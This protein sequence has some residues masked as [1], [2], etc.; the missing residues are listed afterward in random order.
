VLH[1]PRGLNEDRVDQEKRKTART[2]KPSRPRFGVRSAERLLVA[3]LAD[4]PTGSVLCTSLGRG[5]FALAAAQS[6]P[7]EVFCSFPDLYARNAAEKFLPQPCPNL[8]LECRADFP[9]QE[10]DVFALP[11]S[12]RGDAEFVR[13]LLQSGHERLRIGGMMFVA[14]DN[15]SD[16]WLHDELRKLFAKVTRRPCDRGSLYSATKLEPL[17][18]QKNFECQFAFRDEGRLIQAVSRPG[19]FSHRRVDGGAR[20]LLKAAQV[21][22]G[23]RVLELG[24]GSGVV[25]LALALR[26]E[27]I[28]VQ[29][30][31]SNARAV[32]CTRKGAELNGISSIAVKLSTAELNTA[33][34]LVEQTSDRVDLVVANPPYYSNYRIAEIFA[35]RA[36]R[37]LRSEGT[38]LFVT[39]QTEWY[40]QTLPRLFSSVT[41]EPTG[42]YRIV[43]C[44]GKTR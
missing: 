5:Q 28:H 35:R 23:H 15:K 32:E 24:C 2:L 7:S 1:L 30:I 20:A 10:F 8:R 12:A 16:T 38:A 40:E 36:A 18:K 21:Q 43:R 37:A 29:A 4:I 22:P 42:N 3:A 6:R 19:V 26:G 11:I 31:D 13:D 34:D 25:S 41:V 14:T 9:E 17:R 39:K 44:R 33:E 27:G